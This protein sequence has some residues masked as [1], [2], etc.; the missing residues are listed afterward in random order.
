MIKEPLGAVEVEAVVDLVSQCGAVI[1]Q[2]D[3]VPG[4]IKSF[5]ADL[6]GVGEYFVTGIVPIFIS[7]KLWKK[8][9][10]NY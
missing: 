8:S 1:L 3:H 9:D 5:S 7:T 6:I 10:L 4:K 2:V